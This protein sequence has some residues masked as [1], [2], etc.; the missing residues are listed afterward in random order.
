MRITRKQLN[1]VIQDA[2]ILES[3]P[4]GRY[5]PGITGRRVLTEGMSWE[6]MLKDVAAAAASSG[7]LAVT[8]GAGGDV[9]VDTLFAIDTGKE[10]LDEVES[11]ITGLKEVG[12]VIGRAVDLSI[13][14][15]PAAFLAEVKSILIEVMGMVGERAKKIVNGLAKSIRKIVNKV[16]R[17]IS[18]WVAALFPAD[19]GLAGPGFEMSVT[20]AISS[21]TETAFDS[22]MS[23]IESLGETGR[24]LID[25]GAMEKF[26]EDLT[27]GL[28]NYTDAVQEKLD[29][30]DPEK[31][32]LLKSLVAFEKLRWETMANMSGLAT[33]ADKLGFQTD[34]A[35]E[36]ILQAIESLPPWSPA[37]KMLSGLLPKM[38]SWLETVQAEYIPLAGKIMTQLMSYLFACIA[39]LQLISN[40]EDREELLAAAD[41]KQLERATAI[42]KMTPEERTAVSKKAG[43]DLFGSDVDLDLGLSEHRKLRRKKRMRISERRIRKQLRREL[44]KRKIRCIVEQAVSANVTEDVP[45][46][47]ESL[48]HAVD[49]IELGAQ[50]AQDEFDPGVIISAMQRGLAKLGFSDPCEYVQKERKAIEL[51]LQGMEEAATLLRLGNNP[52]KNLEDFGER[53]QHLGMG[54]GM[55]MGMT[56]AKAYAGMAFESGETLGANGMRQAAGGIGEFLGGVVPDFMGGDTLTK[57]AKEYRAAAEAANDAIQAQA[58][59]A[60]TVLGL[61]TATWMTIGQVLA[62]LAITIWVYKWL[63]KS[64]MACK[65]KNFIV[66]V[67]GVI[68][69]GTRWAYTNVVRPF[70]D[71]VLSWGSGI[72]DSIER[73]LSDWLGAGEKHAMAES[74][75]RRGNLT[76]SQLTSLHEA[77]ALRLQ[78]RVRVELACRRMRN[79]I[80][81]LCNK[82]YGI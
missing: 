6:D 48:Q 28:L 4:Y 63:L 55:L 77:K 22:T 40:E 13:T 3:T 66:D 29:N 20:T 51:E 35:G 33:V 38:T 80:N 57:S 26:L 79:A 44:S 21:V 15:G 41:K 49:S 72:V 11:A 56:G 23:A 45:L 70:A 34:S 69:D 73:K 16:V 5:Y 37:H 61:N 46:T 32:G 42:S 54:A 25:Q 9:V 71:K 1:A 19:F 78:E 74:Y 68:A 58:M 82:K 27:V 62:I 30:P 53:V 81:N 76:R 31:S 14:V 43:E 60:T 12:A 47:A 67:G 59:S 75:H 24:F 18:K 39:L 2:T 8:G 64:G 65:M 7:A 52:A 10:I 50:K 17:A 36:D